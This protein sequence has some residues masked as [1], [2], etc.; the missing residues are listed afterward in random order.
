MIFQSVYFLDVKGFHLLFQAKKVG[1][2]VALLTV[3]E[4]GGL[5]YL[6]A[7][8]DRRIA[9]LL[10]PLMKTIPYLST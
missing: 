8:T 1:Q 3:V 5:M 9:P 7:Y 10:E 6:H 4:P 2:W